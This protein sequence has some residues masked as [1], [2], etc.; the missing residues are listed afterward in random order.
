MNNKSKSKNYMNMNV[1]SQKKDIRI[2]QKVKEHIAENYKILK[3]TSFKSVRR[4]N[5]IHSC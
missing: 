1:Q 4:Y 3:K 2:R 5:I